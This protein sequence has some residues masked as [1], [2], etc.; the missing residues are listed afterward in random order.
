[1]NSTVSD[2]ESSCSNN[3]FPINN[4]LF[5][6]DFQGFLFSSLVLSNLIMMYPVMDFFGLTLFG[7]LSFLNPYVHVFHQIC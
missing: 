4:V 5:S 7:S 1:M 2:E 6:S 3:C